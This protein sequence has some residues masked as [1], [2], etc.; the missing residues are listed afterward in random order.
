MVIVRWPLSKDILDTLKHNIQLILWSTNDY[1]YFRQVF[2]LVNSTTRG[3]SR[4]VPYICSRTSPSDPV[5]SIR[6]YDI[7]Y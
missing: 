4:Q 3:A 5:D 1:S 6:H 2:L 7:C